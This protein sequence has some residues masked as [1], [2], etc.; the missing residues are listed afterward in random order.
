MMEVRSPSDRLA[1]ELRVAGGDPVF[2]VTFD[3]V[4]VMGNGRLG[5]VFAEHDL[6]A[7][8]LETASDTEVL[9]DGYRLVGSDRRID[10]AARQRS[11][12]F[13]SA[14]G[15]RLTLHVRVTDDAIGLRYRWDGDDDRL[16]AD[17]TSF[18]FVSTGRAWIQPHDPPALGAPPTDRARARHL[19]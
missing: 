14:R 17:L 15:G 19:Q 1:F 13:D 11:F 6:S 7:L 2:A 18:R 9:E 4:V 8:T 16:L 12:E 10:V 3:D 5:M